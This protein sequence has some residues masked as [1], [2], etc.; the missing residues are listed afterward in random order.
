MLQLKM[1]YK[2]SFFWPKEKHK[3]INSKPL[4]IMYSQ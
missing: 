1:E 3:I 2:Q 4:F